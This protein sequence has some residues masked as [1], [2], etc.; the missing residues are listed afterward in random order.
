MNL[1]ESI[2]FGTHTCVVFF[3]PTEIV[4]NYFDPNIVITNFQIFNQGVNIGEEINGKVILE[5]SISETDL[6][7]LSYNE[8]VFSLEFS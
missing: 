4:D 8:S 3:A 5:K 6:L 2:Y 1:D 7:Q